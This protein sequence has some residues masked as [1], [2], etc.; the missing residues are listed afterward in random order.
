MSSHPL[1]NFKIQKYYQIESKFNDVYSRK[2]LPEINDWACA[3]N[4]DEYK[5]IGTHWIALYMNGN[6]VIYFDSFEVEHIPKK[7]KNS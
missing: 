7:L 5:S 2:N 6:N 1:T 4:F 3:I